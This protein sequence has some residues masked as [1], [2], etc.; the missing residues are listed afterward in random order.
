[1]GGAVPLKYNKR[2]IRKLNDK[3]ILKK[4]KKNWVVVSV[5][6]FAL[7][8]A[9]SLTL[10]TNQVDAHAD[11]TSNG[12]AATVVNQSTN[13]NS[14]SNSPAVTSDTNSLNNSQSSF[15]SSES[16]VSTSAI[17]SSVQSS[18][19][20]VIN[21]S[22]SSNA[23]NSLTGVSLSDAEAI[24]D[25]MASSAQSSIDSNA[26]NYRAAL[27]QGLSYRDSFSANSVSVY[28]N[29]V[30][31]GQPLGGGAS[32]AYVVNNTNPN[33]FQILNSATPNANG[34][35]QLNN[36]NN[37]TNPGITY[38]LNASIGPGK[39]SYGSPQV[40][41]EIKG[42]N[43]TFLTPVSFVDANGNT[44]TGTNGNPAIGM[45]I[46]NSSN[47]ALQKVTSYYNI[48]GNNYVANIGSQL[49]MDSNFNYVVTL[50]PAAKPKPL[51][52]YNT[53]GN[54]V[55]T[56]TVNIN[57]DGTIT[58][59]YT[60]GNL[61]TK[62]Y[63]VPNSANPSI[64]ADANNNGQ[65]AVTVNQQT[66]TLNFVTPNNQI[67]TDSNNNQ[68][69]GSVY[70]NSDGSTTINDTTSINGSGYHVAPNAKVVAKGNGTYSITVLK[71]A[72]TSTVTFTSK[73]VP[74]V[75]NRGN[76]AIGQVNVNGNNVPQ[77]VDYGNLANSNYH[78]SPNGQLIKDANDDNFT[79]EVVLNRLSNFA[80]ATF[81]D[82][83][84]A[85]HGQGTII[86]DANNNPKLVDN[87]NLDINNYYVVNG[88]VNNINGQYQVL[89]NPY[90][91]NN[92][93]PLT[94]VDANGNSHGT[95]LVF[96]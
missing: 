41:V 65:Y 19:D 39:N 81:V 76:T 88:Q 48:N 8:G 72:R 6:S 44:I 90:V 57:N 61:P 91:V 13:V 43:P 87:G 31:G 9:A 54:L 23:N 92:Q 64:A 24:I 36:I 51:N 96:I 63:Y 60:L 55:G 21:N 50:V 69:T 86:F 77:L 67:L 83:K 84:G 59:T 3:K 26:A 32:Y 1:M 46:L 62:Y 10:M 80:N 49:G 82:S 29:D 34:V 18:S 25:Q 2:K 17:S 93:Y 4:V 78:I 42:T 22:Q 7:F 89:V 47:N 38:V 12:Q 27:A 35:N 71:N 15:I 5:S 33:N 74:V 56:G 20:T 52:F 28:F 79:M 11:G 16:S 53:N 94:F 70:L 45:A 30:N 40:I 85:N 75:D 58:N 68:L 14:Q 73:G 95:G 37:V 66:A